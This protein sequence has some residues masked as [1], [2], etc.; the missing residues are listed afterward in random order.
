MGRFL[1]F[2]GCLRGDLCAMRGCEV[3]NLTRPGRAVVATGGPRF[4]WDDLSGF[5]DRAASACSFMF[6]VKV[7]KAA[8]GQQTIFKGHLSMLSGKVSVS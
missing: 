6:V 8:Y 7:C 4:P 3:A 5:P 1:F 2:K